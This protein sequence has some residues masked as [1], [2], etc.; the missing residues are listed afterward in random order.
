PG[1]FTFNPPGSNQSVVDL[2]ARKS[3]DSGN[4]W[5]LNVDEGSINTSGTAIDSSNANIVYA[6]GY[7]TV[8]RSSDAFE[9]TSCTGSGAAG[10][11]CSDSGSTCRKGMKCYQAT[12]LPLLR[13]V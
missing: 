4:T 11:Q 9:G 8:Y 12:G 5:K 7:A 10:T 1:H 2:G 6:Y 13:R 3:T